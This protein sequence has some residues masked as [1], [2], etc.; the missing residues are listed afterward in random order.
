MSMPI[1]QQTRRAMSKARRGPKNLI[2]DVEGL[3]VGQAADTRVRT[4]VTVV[5]A[6]RLSPAACEVCGGG[7]GTRETDALR[8]EGLVG[9]LDAVVLAGGSVYGLGACDAVAA[10][11]GAAGRGFQ[12]RGMEGAPASPLVGGAILHDLF[13]GGDKAWGEAPP[14]A[15]LGR[16]ALAAAADRF[17]LGAAGAGY[18]A[19][20]GTLKGGIGSASAVTADGITV[21][22]LAAVNSMGSVTGADGRTFWAAPFELDAEFGGADPGRLR[23][24]PD[25]WPG[26]KVD[27]SPRENTTLCVVATDVALTNPELK[28][29]AAMARAGLAQAIR[30]VFTPFDGDVVFAVS[31]TRLEPAEPRAF[32]VARIGALAADTLARAIARGVY[33]ARVA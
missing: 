24:E 18:G 7:P 12:L 27:P 22:A 20:A 28:R 3:L 14:Y 2:T 1:E 21:G 32:T 26:A 4:G 29:V 33:E 23:A 8:P 16:A 25:A 13:N 31:T 11:L 9:G 17:E 10:V 30:P 19:M 6:D 15:A 5:L